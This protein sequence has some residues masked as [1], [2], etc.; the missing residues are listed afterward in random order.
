MSALLSKWSD[1]EDVSDM[2]Q[3]LDQSPGTFNPAGAPKITEVVP[4][5]T[6]PSPDVARKQDDD[7]TG[8]DQDRDLAKPT[9]RKSEAS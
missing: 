1:E 5:P 2:E 7:R 6:P 9:R 4:A 3:D 8:A